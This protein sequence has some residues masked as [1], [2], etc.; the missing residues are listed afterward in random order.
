MLAFKISGY[1]FLF[2][3][4]F[5]FRVSSS[6]NYLDHICPNTTTYSPNSTYRSNLNQLFLAL[7]SNATRNNGFYSY[8]VGR[9]S[10]DRIEGLFLCRGDVNSDVCEE[11]VRNATTNILQRCPMEKAA[12]IWYDECMLGYSNISIFSWSEQNA[13]I[14]L[15]NVQNI[16]DQPDRFRTVLAATLNELATEAANGLSGKKFATKQ[17]NFTGF[18]T[19]Y[20]LAQCTPDLSSGQC[21]TCL[22]DCI[23]NFP[24]CCDLSQGARVNFPSCNIRYEMSPFY[25]FT[26]AP[27]PAPP[28]PN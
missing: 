1:L 26:L 28:P 2:C 17:A 19:L 22:R 14:I 27:A 20:T 13:P 5:L 25:N 23:S 11:C 21:N 8:E 7:S 24:T 16:T 10:P 9:G 6:V 4:L 18:Q 15:L 3:L 12:V